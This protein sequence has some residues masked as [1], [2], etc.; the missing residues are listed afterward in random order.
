MDRK[1]SQLLDEAAQQANTSLMGEFWQFLSTNKKWWLGPIVLMLL[2]L[3]LLLA[4]SGHCRG[5]VYLH[6][7]LTIGH[8]RSCTTTVGWAL[9][10]TTWAKVGG[11]HPTNLAV[12]CSR[13]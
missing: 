11:A 6:V 1:P 12:G 2:L 8:S 10:T 3:G 13:L 4:L 5:T 9:P 7:V